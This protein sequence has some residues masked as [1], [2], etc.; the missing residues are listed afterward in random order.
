MNAPLTVAENASVDFSST[1]L[2]GDVLF[3]GE[4]HALLLTDKE[5]GLPERL[6]VNLE[7]YGLTPRPGHV[8][9]KDWSESTGVTASLVNS[10]LVEIVDVHRVGPFDT[11][12]YEVKVLV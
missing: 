10:G 5:T 8:F 11:T 12:A 7:A 1:T 3:L 9:I 4:Q 2:S 6:S